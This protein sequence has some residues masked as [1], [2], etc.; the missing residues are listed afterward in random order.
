[1]SGSGKM[2]GRIPLSSPF[3]A[4]VDEWQ[5]DANLRC[6]VGLKISGI[7]ISESSFRFP[8]SLRLVL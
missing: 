4:L 2:E 5:K 8:P 3:L 7:S 1:M 6:F